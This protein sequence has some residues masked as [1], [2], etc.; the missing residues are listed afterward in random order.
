MLLTQEAA[1]HGVPMIGFPQ[2]ADQ[3]DNIIRMVAAGTSLQLLDQTLEESS[4]KTTIMRVLEDPRCVLCA[5]W[6]IYVCS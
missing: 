1:Y 6:N 3:F 2:F 4:L 5:P